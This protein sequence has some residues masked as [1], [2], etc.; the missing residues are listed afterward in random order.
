M[1]EFSTGGHAPQ[2]HRFTQQRPQRSEF[3]AHRHLLDRAGAAR[4][5][6]FARVDTQQRAE[7]FGAGEKYGQRI[8]LAKGIA[9]A[10]PT[11]FIAGLVLSVL[12]VPAIARWVGGA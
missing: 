7:D 9:I 3:D 11:G 4:D 12:I 1:Q 6:A 5:Q 2:V 8:G 10:A